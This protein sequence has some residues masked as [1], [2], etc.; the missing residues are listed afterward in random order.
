MSK[1]IQPKL[2]LAKLAFGAAVLAAFTGCQTQ[3]PAPKDVAAQAAEQQDALTLREG[4]VLKISFPG[5]PNLDT[6]QPV[7]RDGKIVLSLVGEVKAA[8]LTPAELQKQLV[9]LYASQLTTKEVM[10]SLQ[11]STFP[12]FV[13]GAVLK[14]GKILSD[15]PITAMEAIMEAG[16]FD[17]AKANLKDVTVLRQEGASLK[18]YSL[19]LQSTLEGKQS[20]SFYLRPSDIVYIRERF[21]W[22]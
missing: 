13:T 7:R 20:Q 5:A 1:M 17:Y 22:F 10:V 2:L 4:D 15:R 3:M 12:V 8:G 21:S 14:P 18:H 16:G 11:T 6:T 9:D 19:D